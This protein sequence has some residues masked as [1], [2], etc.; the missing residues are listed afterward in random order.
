MGIQGGSRQRPTRPAILKEGIDRPFLIHD[1][2]PTTHPAGG[3][4]LV[5]RGNRVETGGSPPRQPARH[6]AGTSSERSRLCEVRTRSVSGSDHPTTF[7]GLQ[8]ALGN[9]ASA[10]QRRP[11]CAQCGGYATDYLPTQEQPEM[12]DTIEDDGFRLG[13]RRHRT[14]PRHNNVKGRCQRQPPDPVRQW[15]RREPAQ[16]GRAAHSR[17]SR[18]TAAHRP[19]ATHRTASRG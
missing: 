19:T 12:A 14:Q 16:Q 13:V 18:Q 8:E 5:G 6:Q 2:P 17:T 15:R 4:S 7:F 3:S 11:V 9:T 1:D 10:L